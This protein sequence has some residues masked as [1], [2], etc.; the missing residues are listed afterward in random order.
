VNASIR[1][2]LLRVTALLAVLGLASGCD[3]FRPTQPAPPSG[4][5]FNAVY[6]SPAA[7]L[8]TLRLAIE[9]KAATNGRVAYLGGIANPD[10][11]GD[12]FSTTFD[13]LTIERFPG[14]STDWS[15][16]REAEFYANLSIFLSTSTFAFTWGDF[17]GA[18][19]DEPD[20]TPAVFYRSYLLRASSDGGNNYTTIGRGNAELH[21]IKVGNLWK[22]EKWIDHEDPQANRELGEESFGHL[23]LSGP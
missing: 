6:D 15:Y 20:A 16:E 11:E 4:T 18:P 21:F 3:Y 2:S 19:D 14:E 5:G 10:G 12:G 8:N 23:R 7:T 17:P 22:L 9:D 1:N 13:P